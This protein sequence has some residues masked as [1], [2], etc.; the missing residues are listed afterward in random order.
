MIPQVNA[1]RQYQAAGR[2]GQKVRRYK[3]ASLTPTQYLKALP[4]LEDDLSVIADMKLFFGNE[5]LDDLATQPMLL[6]Q[7]LDYYESTYQ[8]LRTRQQA[9]PRTEK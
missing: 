3:L 7:K 1:Y 4:Q 8:V 2:G 5:Q 6:K 9:A